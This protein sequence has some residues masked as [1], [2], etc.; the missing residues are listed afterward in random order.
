M[1]RSFV[2]DADY[3]KLLETLK[4]ILS[5]TLQCDVSVIVITGGESSGKSTLMRVM[6]HL[7]HHGRV[8]IENLFPRQISAPEPQIEMFER[9]LI[10]ASETTSTE[11]LHDCHKL[12]NSP[13][14]VRNF[15]ENYHVIE[16]P[17]VLVVALN[18]EFTI[19]D[20]D[21]PRKP[22][23]IHLPNR[24]QYTPNV[25]GTCLLELVATMQQPSDVNIMNLT[26][27]D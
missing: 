15:Y 3:P 14:T 18:E 21:L 13:I 17:G 4:G 19:P 8:R 22:L 11:L 1:L 20:D 25:E 16:R 26:N 10:F 12:V 9:P 7:S 23:Y 24:F 2:S 27:I 5:N 6:S